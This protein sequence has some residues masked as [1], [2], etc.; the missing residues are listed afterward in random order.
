VLGDIARQ[1]VDMAGDTYV[2]CEDIDQRMRAFMKQKRALVEIGG[3]GADLR[4]QYV[5]LAVVKGERGGATGY[6][7]PS[8]GR[9]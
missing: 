4:R 7:R 5:R 2:A 1:L 6:C 3:R 9:G 8:R